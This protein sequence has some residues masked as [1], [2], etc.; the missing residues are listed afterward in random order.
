M[1]SPTSPKDLPAALLAGIWEA[2]ALWESL[3]CRRIDV[4]ESDP[5][6][7]ASRLPAPS[8]SYGVNLGASLVM[9]SLRAL[10]S[11][12][13]SGCAGF[14]TRFARTVELTSLEL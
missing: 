10:C 2:P 4:S 9:V 11:D 3:P 13:R 5:G 1:L 14:G 12:T 7:A 6:R 8:R